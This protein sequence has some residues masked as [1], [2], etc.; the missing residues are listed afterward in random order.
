MEWLGFKPLG[1]TKSQK[2]YICRY[3]E[4][5]LSLEELSTFI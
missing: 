5:D 3:M 4:I 2:K 1:N